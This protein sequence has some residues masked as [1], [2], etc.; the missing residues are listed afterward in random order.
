MAMNLQQRQKNMRNGLVKILCD[1]TA[2]EGAEARNGDTIADAVISYKAT[3]TGIMDISLGKQSGKYIYS[4]GWWQKES[5]WNC[6][7]T[8][9]SSTVQRRHQRVDRNRF[10]GDIKDARGRSQE[11][12][13]FRAPPALDERFR[14]LGSTSPRR[15]CDPFPAAEILLV[16]WNTQI[17]LAVDQTLFHLSSTRFIGS[18]VRQPFVALPLPNEKGPGQSVVFHAEEYA[19]PASEETAIGC[20]AKMENDCVPCWGRPHTLLSGRGAEF[21]AAASRAIYQMLPRLKGVRV[22][23]T[24]MR[25]YH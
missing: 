11:G 3:G 14:A 1:I 16:D 4:D 7:A 6:P 21:V 12:V 23:F 8:K 25:T 5:Y 20:T 15:E 18:A 2:S 19:I 22:H 9:V 10:Q 17:R 24:P 13:R